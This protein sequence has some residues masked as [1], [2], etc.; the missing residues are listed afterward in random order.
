[1]NSPTSQAYRHIVPRAPPL[2]L[3][4]TPLPSQGNV[5]WMK[6]REENMHSPLFGEHFK[7]LLPVV[8]VRIA[9]ARAPPFRAAHYGRI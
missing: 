2:S 5:N 6:M 1:M 7:D 8:Q 4:P 3:P 9:T